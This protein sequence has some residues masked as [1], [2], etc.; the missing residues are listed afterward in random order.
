MAAGSGNGPRR[1]EDPRRKTQDPGPKTEADKEIGVCVCVVWVARI[2]AHR[3]PQKHS[4]PG[5]PRNMH[6]CYTYTQAGLAPPACTPAAAAHR[7][8]DLVTT[9][10]FANAENPA[11]ERRANVR[12]CPRAW[13]NARPDH[14]RRVAMECT[15]TTPQPA[16]ARNPSVQ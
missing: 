10:P 5:V 6:S 12:V 2:Y 13:P 8:G 7:R 16:T 9:R 3:R 15:T 14:E 1:P 11:N 4:S